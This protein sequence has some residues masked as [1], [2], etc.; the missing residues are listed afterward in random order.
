MMSVAMTAVARM[1]WWHAPLFHASPFTGY[2]YPNE[3]IVPWSGLIYYSPPILGRDG[4]VALVMILILPLLFLWLFVRLF[5]PWDDMAEERDL[6]VN[7]I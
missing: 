3:T 7:E 5:P 4:V 6:D 2:V 1:G